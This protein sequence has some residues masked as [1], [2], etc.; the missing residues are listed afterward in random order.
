IKGFTHLA[1]RAFLSE[2]CSTGRRES[3]QMGKSFYGRLCGSDDWILVAAD[4]IARPD[5]RFSSSL[6]SVRRNSFIYRSR[7]RIGRLFYCNHYV[8]KVGVYFPSHCT[9]RN[10]SSAGSGDPQ[11]HLLGRGRSRVWIDSLVEAPKKILS[12]ISSSPNYLGRRSKHSGKKN[13]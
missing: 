3:Y 12:L 1:S 6:F 7:F 11:S 4:L 2:I 13:T 9:C 10:T 8:K 5:A